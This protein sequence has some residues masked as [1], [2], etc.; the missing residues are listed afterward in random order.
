MKGYNDS[1]LL[2]M[3][4]TFKSIM[5]VR[6]R[7]RQ[8]T[9]IF[10]RISENMCLHMQAMYVLLRCLSV[11]ECVITSCCRIKIILKQ[12]YYRNECS[13]K[14]SPQGLLWRSSFAF[15]MLQV[16]VSYD[17][18]CQPCRKLVCLSISCSVSFVLSFHSVLFQA[19]SR[20]YCLLSC[21]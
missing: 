16:L 20:N 4:N 19:F 15:W 13:L 14:L 9:L 8:W 12:V 18:G 2:T 5:M 3:M 1:K 7:M 11:W 21:L 10:E 6:R 17:L